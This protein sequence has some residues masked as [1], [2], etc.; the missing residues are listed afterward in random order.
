MMGS[1]LESETTAATLGQEGVR[2]FN[3]MSI[4]DFLSYPLSEYIMNNIKF[5]QNLEK[6][7][8]VYGVNYLLR[9]TDGK[10][11]NGMHDKHVWLKWAELRV[12]GDVSA[13]LTPLGYIPHYSDLKQLF[14]DVLQKE[15]TE[16][17]YTEQFTIRIPQILEKTDRIRKI[18]TEDVSD[19]PQ[20]LID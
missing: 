20:M 2:K 9:G 19:T 7:L 14:K 10:Y 1:S 8:K 12:H 17:H 3:L 4:L 11:L 16:E 6:S 5:G 13:I 15:Y 18:Y